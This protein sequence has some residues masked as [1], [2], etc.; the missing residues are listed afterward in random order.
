LIAN[1]HGLTTSQLANPCL[2]DIA[3]AVVSQMISQPYFF[4]EIR[5]LFH[6]SSEN[7]F[8]SKV[9]PYTLPH[10]FATR[11]R[12]VLDKI[13]SIK[14]E[15]FF[16]LS[17]DNIHGILAECFLL[18]DQHDFQQAIQFMLNLFSPASG[19]ALTIQPLVISYL[20]SVILSLVII[21][22]EDNQ[23]RAPIVS[24]CLTVLELYL[25]HTGH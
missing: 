14:G 13:A 25:P 16:D 18:K 5:R 17:Q 9:F 15:T 19:E 11:N 24:C 10:L 2:K 8:L 21:V 1:K 12:Q 6:H 22:G 3:T 20:V 4:H 23:Q 7:A